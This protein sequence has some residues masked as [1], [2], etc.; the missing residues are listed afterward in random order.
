MY[1]RRS[2][3]ALLFAEDFDEPAEERTPEIVSAPPTFSASELSAACEEA[4]CEALAD[5]RLRV[6]E[7]ASHAAQAALATIAQKMAGHNDEV[8]KIANQHANG[9][10]ELLLAIL[11]TALP[12]LCARHAARE[13]QAILQTLR[14]ALMIEPTVTVHLNPATAQALQ[15]EIERLG[16]TLPGE[17]RVNATESMAPTNLHVVWRDGS[18]RRDVKALLAAIDEAL[19]GIGLTE[20]IMSNRTDA[21][22]SGR[23]ASERLAHEPRIKDHTHG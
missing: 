17:L 22:S 15:V 11:R 3:P 16:A 23:D 8:V 20:I 9:M 5:E 2:R 18:A 4:V 1:N 7:A 13:V 6:V 14:P 21:A 12:A 10:A 19:L